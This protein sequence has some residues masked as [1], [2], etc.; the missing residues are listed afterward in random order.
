M[1]QYTFVEAQQEEEEETEEKEEEEEEEEEEREGGM[2]A[3]CF[4]CGLPRLA[5]HLF[6]H[7]NIVASW[8]Q[9]KNCCYFFDH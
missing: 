9:R 3:S 2:L 1:R 5:P 4:A 6:C 8:W 7:E